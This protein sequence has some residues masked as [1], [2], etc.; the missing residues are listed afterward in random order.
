MSEK[1]K[2]IVLGCNYYIGLSIIRCLGREGIYV[3][4][5]DHDEEKAYALKSKYVKDVLI[6]KNLF[7]N[8]KKA[9]QELVNYAKN[10]KK[11]PVLIP[12][13]DKY[14]EFIDEYYDIL[15]KYFLI[16]QKKNLNSELA[17]KIKLYEKCD[18]YHIKY[19]EIIYV[20]DKRLLEKLSKWPHK[21]FPCIL[22]PV[23][24]VEFA[25]EFKRKTFKCSNEKELREKIKVCKEKNIEVFV[26]RIIP[27]FD[28]HMVTF[29]AF[30][31][32]EGKLVSWMTAQKERQWPIN[33]GASVFTK[34][35]YIENVRKTGEEI[36][37]ALKYQGFGEIEFKIDEESK[38]L[39]LIEINVRVT[40]FNNLIYKTGINMPYLIYKDLTSKIT[41]EDEKG[42]DYDTNRAFVSLRE[43]I[44]SIIAYKKA[45]QVGIMKS[46]SKY[47]CRLAPSVFALYDLKPW[48]IHNILYWKRKLK[49]KR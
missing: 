33:F 42:I 28:D 3:V 20:S 32:K 6:I 44:A 4:G 27:G 29:D 30:I 15:S 10:E 9:V 7:Q 22:K 25:K 47:F 2:A 43:D 1:I 41:K 35:K 8:N 21:G 45:K 40:N 49:I 14:V 17:D 12:S 26:Q 34:Q 48:H 46:L 16:S 37:K 18:K 38:E 31:S 36:F 13:H 19:P 23:D 5:C 39:Y 24:T 11:K